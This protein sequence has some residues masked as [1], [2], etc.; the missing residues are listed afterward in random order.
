MKIKVLLVIPNQEVQMVKI[1][2]NIKFIKAFIGENLFKIKLDKNN[3]LIANKNADICDF[4]RVVG[5]N[6]YLELF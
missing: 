2:A 4:N 5:T 1:P 6:T 3:I